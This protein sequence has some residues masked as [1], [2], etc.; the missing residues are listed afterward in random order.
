[1]IVTFCSIFPDYEMKPESPA[2]I[3]LT[4]KIHLT[5]LWEKMDAWQRL[6]ADTSRAQ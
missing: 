2:E 4:K 1:M 3:R 6:A 5:L